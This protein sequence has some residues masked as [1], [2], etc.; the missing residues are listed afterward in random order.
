MSIWRAK[1]DPNAEFV[2]GKPFRFGV[3]DFKRGEPFNHHTSAR[4]LRTF[5]DARLMDYAPTQPDT[6]TDSD[7]TEIPGSETNTPTGGR[8]ISMVSRGWYNVL[9]TDG[10]KLNDKKLRLQEAEA[11]VAQG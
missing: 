5:Y 10:N 9:D 4:Q 3:H 2:V 11:L 7:S 6:E 8:R 1:F